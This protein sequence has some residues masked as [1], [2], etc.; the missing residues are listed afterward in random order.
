MPNNDWIK[1]LKP[2]DQVVVN[3]K[4]LKLVERVTPSGR[5][6]VGGDTFNPDG[7]KRGDKD[8]WNHTYISEA[9]PEAVQRIKDTETV[10]E[11][12]HL[13]DRVSRMNYLLTP[14]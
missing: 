5:V 14:T 2:G 7:W 9:T 3:G 13:A 11:A 4:Y 10:G 1:N 12:M 8:A 6:V